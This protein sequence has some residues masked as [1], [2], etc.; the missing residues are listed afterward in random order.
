VDTWLTGTPDQAKVLLVPYPPELMRAHPVS[1]RL[2]K[3]E[4]DD[5]ELL[6]LG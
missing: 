3:P 5:L 2:N 1:K 6:T 4:N